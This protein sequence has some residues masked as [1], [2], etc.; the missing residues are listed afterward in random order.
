MSY[1]ATNLTSS[2]APAGGTDARSP[3]IDLAPTRDGFPDGAWCPRSNDLVAA[4]PELFAAL[5]EQNL[6]VRR[7][8]YHPTTWLAAPRRLV[9][10]SRRV[11]L[12]PSSAFHPHLLRLFLSGSNRCMD[13]LVILPAVSP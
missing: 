12:S 3:L 7:V 4:L 10:D 11:D 1:P 5:G 2:L 13:L 8:V 9:S 6:L